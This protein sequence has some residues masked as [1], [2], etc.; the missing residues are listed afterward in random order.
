MRKVATQNLQVDACQIK[1]S[2]R[3][4]YIAMA[5][6]WHDQKAE[7]AVLNWH[8]HYNHPQHHQLELILPST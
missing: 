7:L 5:Q 4:E 2:P 3:S 6:Q 8:M 1:I